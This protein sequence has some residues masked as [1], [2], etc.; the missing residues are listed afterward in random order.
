MDAN[1]NTCNIKAS[2]LVIAWGVM[3]FI[4]DKNPILLWPNVDQGPQCYLPYSN[5]KW[6]YIR[7]QILW[8]KMLLFNWN[9]SFDENTH[10]QP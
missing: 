5:I 1:G 2:G 7:K 4:D 8:Y 10:D 3:A 6:H 9:F